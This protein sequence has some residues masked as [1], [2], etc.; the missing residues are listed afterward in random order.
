MGV[1]FLGLLRIQ[2]WLDIRFFRMD[3]MAQ[4]MV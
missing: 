4:W 2:V 3:G 1:E